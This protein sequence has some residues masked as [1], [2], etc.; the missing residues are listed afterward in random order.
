MR[1]WPT[2]ASRLVSKLDQN[3]QKYINEEFSTPSNRPKSGT[4]LR[5]SSANQNYGTLSSRNVQVLTNGSNQDVQQGSGSSFHNTFPTKRFGA[6]SN[7]Q[8]TK[9]IVNT[10]FEKQA[11]SHQLAE[12]IKMDIPD[13]VDL[14]VENKPEPKVS[15]KSN[16]GPL[17]L[18][19]T[20]MNVMNDLTKVDNNSNGNRHP[21]LHSEVIRERILFLQSKNRPIRCG[22]CTWTDGRWWE[23]T[24]E[25]ETRRT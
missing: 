14:D 4:S 15:T 20:E 19:R 18:T 24:K 6:T 2:R 3:I 12:K 22:I 25:S 11:N 17:R 7:F 8:V 13:K 5:P 9:E 1:L 10:N 21:I 16:S 23:W